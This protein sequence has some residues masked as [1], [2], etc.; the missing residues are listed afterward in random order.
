MSF[1]EFVYII[2]AAGF[3]IIKL[4]IILSYYPFNDY[5]GSVVI[6]LPI[7]VIHIFFFCWSLSILIRPFKE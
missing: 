1:K 6:T 7:L 2:F 4:F 5:I 3:L